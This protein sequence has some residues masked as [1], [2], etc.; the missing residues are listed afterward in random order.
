MDNILQQV[1]SECTRQKEKWGEQN[2]HP[3]MWNSILTEET[4]ES[5]KEV[6]EY[7]FGDKSALLRLRTELIQVAAVAVSAIDSL[8]RNELKESEVTHA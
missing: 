5:A 6:N 3:V 8:D 7:T 1:F 4:G 2:H